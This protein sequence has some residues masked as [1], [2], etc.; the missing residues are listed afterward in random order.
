MLFSTVKYSV[1]SAN[2]WIAMVYN[3]NIEEK[4]YKEK[5]QERLSEP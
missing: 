3:Y 4:S 5:K 2:F 1:I